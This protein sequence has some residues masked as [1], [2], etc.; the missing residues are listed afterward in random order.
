[1]TKQMHHAMN[2]QMREMLIEANPGSYA[3]CCR[4]RP[5]MLVEHAACV[6]ADYPH[7][8]TTITDV[9]LMSMTGG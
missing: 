3:R 4:T 9:G 1:M 7:S 2:E 5:H 8:H 6:P